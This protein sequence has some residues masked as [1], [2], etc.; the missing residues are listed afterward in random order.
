VYG[1][2]VSPL[3]IAAAKINA[4][5]NGI[6]NAEFL[7]ASSEDIFGKVS[8]LDSQQTSVIIDPP[9]KGCDEVFLN[10]LFKFGPN[11][12]VYVSCD[13]ATQARDA[14]IIKEV[15]GYELT[16]IQPFDL[17]PQTRHIECVCVFERK[18]SK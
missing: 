17:F 7:C 4:Q 2:E 12:L 8:H 3:S 1:V 9:R 15:G 10:K 13:P 11:R 18:R 5:D 6:Q 14:K 16:V